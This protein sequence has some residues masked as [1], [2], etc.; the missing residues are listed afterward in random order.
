MRTVAE[1]VEMKQMMEAPLIYAIRTR[2]PAALQDGAFSAEDIA[3]DLGLS[4]RSLQRR[5]TAENL[6]FQQLLDLY[7]QEQA[8][9]L[10]QRGDRDMASIAYALGYNEQ[11]SFNRAF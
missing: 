5:L 9:L 6:S 8:M 2:L 3:N 7:R 4:R 1:Q 11:S 10:L